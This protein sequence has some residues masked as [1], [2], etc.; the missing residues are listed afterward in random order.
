MGDSA[1]DAVSFMGR[2]DYVIPGTDEEWG[3]GVSS[4]VTLF[5]LN[6]KDCPRIVVDVV[7]V[8][9]RVAGMDIGLGKCNQTWLEI[10][11]EKYSCRR[12]SRLARD[13]CR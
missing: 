12:R 7:K 3:S 10:P 13:F 8:S 2:P 5:W 6:G 9:G 4:L 11:P 1:T